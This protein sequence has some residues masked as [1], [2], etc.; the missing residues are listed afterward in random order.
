MKEGKYYDPS[1]KLGSEVKDGTGVQTYWNTSGV[2][3]WELGLK[4]Y[5]RARVS[6]WDDN[7]KLLAK[8]N[9]VDGRE[10]DGH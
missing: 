1:G 5:K 6:M 4:G 8:K 10:V 7:G 9:Y 2:K 3:V